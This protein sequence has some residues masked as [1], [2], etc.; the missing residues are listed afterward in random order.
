M[1][2]LLIIAHD[3]TFTPTEIL[4]SDIQSWVHDMEARGIRKYGNPLRP[5]HDAKT[6]RIRHDLLEVVDAPF[7][8][9]KEK[10]CAYELIECATFEEA[11]NI[12][13]QHPMAK[14]ATIEVR[15]IWSDL[16]L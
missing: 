3:D 13:T 2:F 9:A 8:N 1:Q 11:V 16:A 12:A 5:A 10:I 4:V 6:V 14:A 15:P 7:S